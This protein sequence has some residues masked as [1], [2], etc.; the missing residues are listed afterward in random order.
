MHKEQTYK[1]DYPDWLEQ[2][3]MK[4]LEKNPNDR[5]KDGKELYEDYLRHVKNT[6]IKSNTFS[7]Q[8]PIQENPIK[9]CVT[10]RMWKNN[11]EYKSLYSDDNNYVYFLQ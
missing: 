11:M 8:K 5:Y 1:K 7:N 2:I 10:A 4:C 3:I 9:E 6:N